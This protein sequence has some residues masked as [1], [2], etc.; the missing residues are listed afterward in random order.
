MQQNIV[1]WILAIGIFVVM[2]RAANKLYH[3]ILLKYSK[4]LDKLDNVE[5]VLIDIRDGTKNF[6]REKR[7]SPRVQRCISAKLKGGEDEIL[8]IDNISYEGALL[9]T[10]RDLKRNEMVDLEIFLPLYPQ[11]ITVKSKVVN[12]STIRDAAKGGPKFE[13]SVKFIEISPSDKERLREAVDIFN[14]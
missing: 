10:G 12:T 1:L 3:H 5:R 9:R 8:E 4:V 14:K 13:A 2:L 6:Y 11:P 7:S